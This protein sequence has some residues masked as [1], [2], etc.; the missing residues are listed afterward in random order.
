V[1]RLALALALAALAAPAGAVTCEDLEFEGAPYT[2]CEVSPREERLR[3]FL[4]GPDGKPFGGFRAVEAA[5]GLL[6]FATNAGMYHEDRR[7]VGLFLQDGEEVAPLVTTDGPGNF[8]LL[9]NGLLC[10]SEDGA[11]VV[12]T[13]AYASGRGRAPRPR[14]RGRCW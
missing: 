14:S 1:I 12:E 7:P 8:G 3:L 6:A 4:D 10:L 5:E 13:L 9:P 11:F 2:V